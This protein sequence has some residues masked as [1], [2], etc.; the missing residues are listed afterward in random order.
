[1]AAEISVGAARKSVVSTTQS[2]AWRQPSRVSF[3][4]MKAAV[5]SALVHYS[6]RSILRTILWDNNPQINAIPQRLIFIRYIFLHITTNC[7]LVFRTITSF[8]NEPFSN[9][10]TMDTKKIANAIP[11]ASQINRDQLL[12]IG[13]LEAFKNDLLSE[14]KNLLRE[15]KGQLQKQWLRSSD[16]RK[17]LGISQGTL[18]TFRVNGILSYTKVGGIMFYNYQQVIKLMDGGKGMAG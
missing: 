12:T 1:M 15:S 5:R 18:Q 17:M 13:D 2:N 9:I 14:I 7:K 10:D 3:D 6:Q 4:N 16:V 11:K 8:F